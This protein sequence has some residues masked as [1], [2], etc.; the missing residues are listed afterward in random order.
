MAPVSRLL[1]ERGISADKTAAILFSSGATGA[2]KGVVLSHHNI[3]SNI[4]SLR[5]VFGL[6]KKDGLC[7]A[8]PLSQSL[9]Y[10]A[11]LWYPLLSGV[12]IAY[13]SN[14]LEAGTLARLARES[15]STML[16]ATPTLLRLYIRKAKKEDFAALRYV[17]VGAEKLDPSLADLFEKKFGLRP[18]EGYGLTELA[19]V[20]ALSVPHADKDREFQTGWKKGSVGLP[21]PGIAMKVVDFETGESLEAGRRGL[22]MIKGPNV[23]KGYLNRPGLTAEVIKN[24]WY[25]SDDV[26]SIDEEGFVTIEDRFSR[27]TMINGEMVPH[28]AIEQILQ[29]GL[30]SSKRIVAVSSIQD[31]GGNEKLAVLHTLADA[32]PLRA[33]LAAS[34]LRESWK[35]KPDSYF[36]VD[37]IP[38]I[39]GKLNISAIRRILKTF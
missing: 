8:L 3:L 1:D 22:L 23:M 25:L 32:E 36:K 21:L 17:L 28:L 29:N 34:H 15:G 20:A 11:A 39:S 6:T 35:P 16:F 26:A 13:H 30:G 18:L 33:I 31:S 10:T 5:I 38:V 7:S 37:R 4:E 12:P 27:F 9:G 2:P 19:P 14:P 24:G